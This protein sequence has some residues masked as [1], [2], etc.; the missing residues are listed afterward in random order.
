HP[1]TDPLPARLTARRRAPL[2]RLSAQHRSRPTPQPRPPG[3]TPPVSTRHRP[4]PPW[5][6]ASPRA[7]SNPHHRLHRRPRSDPSP[8][9]AG[10]SWA[11][12]GAEGGG[13]M[14]RKRGGGPG[15]GGPPPAMSELA[16]VAAPEPAST[17]PVV[18]DRGSSVGSSSPAPEARAGLGESAFAARESAT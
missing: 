8:L 3:P 13:R 16:R 7:D 15:G 14:G 11:G 9:R 18:S 12:A 17:P 6:Q 5:A 2:L 10:R 4:P 1:R